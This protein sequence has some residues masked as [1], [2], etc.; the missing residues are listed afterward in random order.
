MVG[1]KAEQRGKVRPGNVKLFF[2]KFKLVLKAQ[3]G[4]KAEFCV[5]ERWSGWM[6]VDTSPPIN[7]KKLFCTEW[8]AV[9]S[10]YPN[11]TRYPTFFS[12]PDPTRTSFEN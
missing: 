5:D 12:I 11:P 8:Q 7:V 4:T 10:G 3:K 9:P 2:E 1:R 6:I